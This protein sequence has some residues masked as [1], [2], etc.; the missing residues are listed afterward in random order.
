MTAPV[1]GEHLA[2]ILRSAHQRTLELVDGLTAAQLMGPKLAIVNPMQWEIGHVAWFHEQFILRREHG[3]APMLE[4]GDALYDSIAI[5][6]DLRWDLPLYTMPQIR[7]YMERVLDALIARLDRGLEDERDSYLYQFT[8]FHEDMHCE[9]YCWT[10]QT[11]AHPVPVFRPDGTGAGALPDAPAGAPAEGDA[12][13]PGGTLAMGS[14]RG[15]AFHFDNE[16][17]SHEVEVAPFR[18]ARTPV[19]NRE[20]AAFVDDGGYETRS[21]W[22]DDGWAWREAADAHHPVYWRPGWEMRS[23]DRWA[24]LPAARPAIHI[25]W[26]EADAWCRWA[27]RR[28]PTEAEW[29]FAATMRPGPDGSL[30]K[31][32]YPWGDDA[33]DP[34]RA[35][36]DGFALGS[37]DAQAFPGGDNAWGVRQ[38]IG[39][40]W[41]WTAD[42]FGPFPGFS[43]DDYREYSEP[44]FGTTKVLRGGAWTTRRRMISSVYRNYFGPERR[45][46]FGGFR[47]CAIA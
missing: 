39:N 8:T 4:R 11:L 16:K 29:E 9:A 22:C 42:T 35:N 24:E 14:P 25:N 1:T 5:A 23:F 37:V 7:D 33:P 18:M 21:L 38:L 34:S 44:L 47:T 36:L 40:V 6:H 41:E 31:A 46:V 13:I 2:A 19:T 27:G 15:A 10:R 17:W 32:R 20:F 3:Q 26:Y 28:L 30:S 43:P 12:R 45:D